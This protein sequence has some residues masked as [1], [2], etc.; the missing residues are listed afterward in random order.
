MK[1]HLK[2]NCKTTE[3]GINVLVW[4]RLYLL[5]FYDWFSNHFEPC[6]II[7]YVKLPVAL[8]ASGP[9]LKESRTHVRVFRGPHGDLL[10]SPF[11]A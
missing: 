8:G 7:E 2:R 1:A 11:A 6:C 5:K 4:A 10:T 3:G 9:G